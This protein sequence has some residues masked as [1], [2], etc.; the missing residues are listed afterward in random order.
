VLVA[1]L[2]RDEVGHVQER[3]SEE[4]DTRALHVFDQS[5]A[6]VQRALIETDSDLDD[7]IGVGV[8][9]PAPLTRDGTIGSPTLLPAWANLRPRAEFSQRLQNVAVKAENDASLGA[10]GEYLFGAGQG[11]DEMTYLQLATGVGSGK[12]LDGRLHRGASG[13]AGEFGHITLDTNGPVCP[14]GNR[15]CV[16]LY[17][18]GVSL[19]RQARDA[20]ESLAGLADLADLVQRATDSDGICR[21]LVAEAG[22][23]LGVA[24]GTLVNLDNPDRV[25]VGGDLVRAGEIL[26]RPLRESMHRTAMAAAANAAEIRAGT[27]GDWATAWGG[28]G[29]ILTS[30]L[31]LGVDAS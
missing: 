10:L 13:T 21:T 28:A 22:G 18:G 19:V 24:L 14:C 12:V 29:L 6:L 25:V 26:L 9:I 23:H 2:G 3:L 20:H 1:D 4:A 16:E 15:G 27:L 8:G 5:A 7:V 17:A 31:A 30:P 11:S